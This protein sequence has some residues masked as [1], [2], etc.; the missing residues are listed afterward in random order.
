MIEET[1][2]AAQAGAAPSGGLGEGDCIQSILHQFDTYLGRYGI[3]AITN[4]NTSGCILR[5]TD[6]HQLEGFGML[7]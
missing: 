5:D 7:C 3:S 4:R 1:R 2:C 6:T